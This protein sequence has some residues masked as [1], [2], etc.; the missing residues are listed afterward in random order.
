MSLA[1][2]ISTI[3][4]TGQYAAVASNLGDIRILDSLVVIPGN[5]SHT[6]ESFRD[7]IEFCLCYLGI[8]YVALIHSLWLQPA[9]SL[10]R[11]L[12]YDG[13]FLARPK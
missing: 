3:M 2:T 12:R 9:Y 10:H 11:K 8:P 7:Q 5:W 6:Y 1:V 4:C 13:R